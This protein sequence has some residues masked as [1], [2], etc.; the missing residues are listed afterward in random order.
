MERKVFDIQPIGRFYG[1]SAAIRRPKEIACFS[2]DDHHK[3]HIGESSLKYYYTPHLPADLNRGFESFQKLDDSADEHLD[4]LLETIMALEQD[5]GIKCE[6]DI[7]TWRGMMTKILTAPFDNMNG[8]VTALGPRFIEENNSYKNEQKWIQRSQRTPPGI[9]SQDLMAYWGYKFETVS[10]LKQ[11]WDSTPRHEI[12]SREEL[13]VNN[14]AQYCSVVRTAIGRSKLVIGGEV[15]AIWDRKPDRKEDPINWVE[16]KT[17]A[18]IRNDRDMIKYERKLLKFWAQSFLLG[19]PRIIVG[20]RDQHGIVKCLEELDT[21]S[22]PGKVKKVGRATWDGNI[23]INFAAEFLQWL[24]SAIQEEGT[25]RI[26]KRE[27]SSIIE[28]YKVEDS[29]TGDIISPAFSAWRS[30]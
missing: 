22:I 5:T 20:F 6:A 12:E 29:G 26:A 13:V 2:Y 8:D 18:E 10:L 23:C 14:N 7:I 16:L 15:D 28:V 17:S 3:F 21:A 1:A 4:A 25:W 11:P 27:R 30:E 9:A 19:V 24:K